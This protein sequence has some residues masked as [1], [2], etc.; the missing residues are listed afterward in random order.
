MSGNNAVLEKIK[1]T[2]FSLENKYYEFV[3]WLADRGIPFN[4]VVDAIETRGI[5]SFPI[6]AAI[7]LALIAVPLVWI[8]SMV[9]QPTYIIHITGPNGAPYTGPVYLDGKLFY[10]RGGTVKV[11]FKPESVSVNMKGVKVSVDPSTLQIKLEA[12]KHT[13][14]VKAV[15]EDGQPVSD[16]V[17]KV[18]GKGTTQTV[19][20][21]PAF[22]TL[23]YT[24]EN[25]VVVPYD[26]GHVNII[27]SADGYETATATANWSDGTRVTKTVVLKKKEAPKGAITIV[28]NPRINGIIRLYKNG[29]SV[30]GGTATINGGVA[31][32]TGIP[33]GTYRAQV[34]VYLDD[35]GQDKYV[36][37][38]N[39]F[40]ITIDK[41]STSTTLNISIP[42][43]LASAQPVTKTSQND[44]VATVYIKT[45][46][47]VNG[48]VKLMQNGV[49]VPGL[50]AELSN[51]QAEI[52]N[53]PYGNYTAQVIVN[54]GGKPYV[55]PDN[56]FD[57]SVNRDKVMKVVNLT[58]PE[59]NVGAKSAKIYVYDAQ[60]NG[61]I[62]D[63][64][65]L[66]VI[67]ND[68]IRVATT[69]SNGTATIIPAEGAEYV[70]KASGYYV[71]DP[72]SVSNG[73]KRSV[74]L[75]PI[76]HEGNVE[77]TVLNKFG[78]PLEGARVQIT[79]DGKTVATGNTRTDG[80]VLFANIPAG[81]CKVTAHYGAY[82]GTKT[83][84]VL[85]KQ[86]VK[87]TVTVYVYERVDV[88]V[89]FLQNGM[90][91]P[92][93]ATVTIIDKAGNIVVGPK[94]TNG[95]GDITLE[96]PQGTVAKVVA[97]A[98]INIG[99]EYNTFS[100][101]TGYIS[102][103]EPKRVKILIAQNKE[104]ILEQYTAYVYTYDADTNM[105]ISGAEIWTDTNGTNTKIA[106]TNADGIA[107]IILSKQI[108][109]FVTAPHYY[110][111]P[112][113]QIQARHEY[114]VPL[115]YVPK[116]GN[117]VVLIK[118]VTGNPRAGVPVMLV[119]ENSKNAI[120][121]SKITNS[122][123]I[124]K[125]T[126]IPVGRYQVKAQMQMGSGYYGAYGEVT[127]QDQKEVNV[128]LQMDLYAHVTVR[129]LLQYKGEELPVD[130]NVTAMSAND[131]NKTY[132]S[133]VAH[134]GTITIPVPINTKIIIRAIV[135]DHGQL[136]SAAEP[137]KEYSGNT[138]ITLIL[139]KP[140]APFAELS[141]KYATSEAKK[142]VWVA[143]PGAKYAWIV[144]YGCNRKCNIP[145]HIDG[146]AKIGDIV[147]AANYMMN[148]SGTDANVD[149][150][151]YG[152]SWCEGAFTVFVEPET[153]APD[154]ITLNVDK[155][156]G[157]V[158]SGPVEMYP[159]NGFYAPLVVGGSVGQIQRVTIPFEINGT[160]TNISVTCANQPKGGWAKVIDIK[161]NSK[162]GYTS[163]IIDL[164]VYPTQNSI[165][166]TV[167]ADKKQVGTATLSFR[168][169]LKSMIVKVAPQKIYC[170]GGCKNRTETIEVNAY[171]GSTGDLLDN[172]T[173]SY[174]IA[175]NCD[176]KTI[177]WTPAQAYTVI[178]PDKNI[179][180]GDF[181]CIRAE[182]I[183]YVPETKIISA[184]KVEAQAEAR[185]VE[186][187][188]LI[189]G[190][191]YVG[192]SDF[193]VKVLVRCGTYPQSVMTGCHVEIP[194]NTLAYKED[195]NQQTGVGTVT[196]TGF[197]SAFKKLVDKMPPGSTK[198]I[199]IT[200]VIDISGGCQIKGTPVDFNVYMPKPWQKCVRVELN[201]PKILL[202]ETH[203]YQIGKT[204]LEKLGDYRVVARV[205]LNNEGDCKVY[206]QGIDANLLVRAS[207][208]T[209]V[210][211][212]VQKMGYVYVLAPT[213]AEVQPGISKYTA[214]M[215]VCY[216]SEC[217]TFAKKDG[218]LVVWPDLRNIAVNINSKQGGKILLTVAGL[219]EGCKIVGGNN[220]GSIDV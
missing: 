131:I 156:T 161:T 128:I 3:E 219:P 195:I 48:E 217:K 47:A 143:A 193:P 186:N 151:C 27:V 204:F 148:G 105:P 163:G 38:D 72:F 101:E 19:D 79:I 134:G 75:T 158:H 179:H 183:G 120:P 164:N 64:K 175:K 10:A 97:S 132:A 40:T 205:E 135:N 202:D 172:Y 176:D 17:V 56:A 117:V 49:F 4:R 45:Q 155:N 70:V 80:T 86:T 147:G 90:E 188:S 29:F 30:D 133:G 104:G 142:Q 137:P 31:T 123:G 173:V 154:A 138:A 52:D 108:T 115:K 16:A 18:L 13:L 5:P 185:I 208:W 121:Q 44:L 22:F 21:S 107:S 66:Q 2:Y 214:S 100:N 61:P 50:S 192:V 42:E 152:G 83:I 203:Y 129:T 167:F 112:K 74:A 165:G 169:H 122:K 59:G 98:K 102:F 88:H 62:R 197:T 34:I 198:T 211:E 206:R 194:P 130:A 7:V 54:V 55:S 159:A 73:E 78:Q 81:T 23:E 53:V 67:D 166:C 144:N 109:V 119:A 125:F 94:T 139:R 190:E 9:F 191:F 95:N 36:N 212:H 189:G 124:A 149:V 210:K 20:G 6:F 15:D 196:I 103:N 215:T 28:T 85:D 140:K 1:S 12:E 180:K 43:A 209:G 96:I 32:L 145:I 207:G 89:R 41:P 65:I 162:G 220:P 171:D 14:I 187:A 199:E 184:A 113:F 213:A 153:N 60:T 82:S 118:D 84:T 201:A 200:P 63:A 25:G 110:A 218:N 68:W 168:G 126:D 181:V 69:D 91:N 157:I 57:L 37:P 46:P 92:V 106:E 39:W 11:H 150:S 93:V 26:D 33:Y 174:K 141:N 216:K 99:G 111:Y 77:I 178:I 35:E 51:G 136:L 127:V 87:D 182:K 58:A 160:Y 146:P 76:P 71:S 8:G 170:V 177:K 114:K 116:E 24:K